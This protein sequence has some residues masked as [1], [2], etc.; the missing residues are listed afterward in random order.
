MH[1][2][3]FR[4]NSPIPLES[5]QPTFKR[6]DKIMSRNPSLK[7]EIE[8]HTNGCSKGVKYSQDLSEA[9]ANMVRNHLMKNG[10]AEKRIRTRG[11]NCSKMLYPK[12]LTGWEQSMNRRV[13]IL[14]TEY[15][16]K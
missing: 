15:S 12:M 14:F 5:A 11:Y 2:I 8:G 9:R 13:E 7:I 16:P 6:L 1:N 10:V 4:G 3:N